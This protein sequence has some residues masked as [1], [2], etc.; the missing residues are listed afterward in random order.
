MKEIQP[1]QVLYE[2]PNKEGNVAVLA[3]W[4]LACNCEHPYRVIS[5]G[6][7]EPVWD[8]NG[9]LMKPTFS[10][11]LLVYNRGTGSGTACHLFVREGKI[12]YCSDCP[13]VLAGKTVP[14]VPL[15]PVRREWIYPE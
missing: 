8:W 15:D 10:P 7:G 3:F 2:Y 13:H 6:H 4:C 5:G 14:M 9:D 12:E 1:G 11:S